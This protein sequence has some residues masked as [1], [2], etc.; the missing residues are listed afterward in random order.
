MCT[1][2]LLRRPGHAWPL[3]LGANRDEMLNRPWRPPGRHW[4][5][6]PDVVAGL[7]ELAGGTWMG[8]NDTG[9][10]ACILNRHGSL[11][12]AAG[13]R[14][15]GELVLEALDHADAAQAAEALSQIDPHAYRPFNMIIADNRDAWWLAL[16]DETEAVRVKAV[17]TGLSMITA[18]ELNDRGEPRVGAF[19]AQF[20]RAAAPDPDAGDWTGW[21]RLLGA[22]GDETAMSF[23]RDNGFGTSSSSLVA[24]PSVKRAFGT[25]PATPIWRFA[26]G[27]P[28]SARF[29][30]VNLG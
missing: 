14:S 13:K 11:G 12:P 18:G 21:E 30:P 24:L 27:P 29:E 25:P 4:A 10:V 16:A 15:R 6:R 9:V 19:L 20:D 2:V 17:P 1:V 5:D 23:R 3:V 26:A 8:L 7:D 22:S 28:E